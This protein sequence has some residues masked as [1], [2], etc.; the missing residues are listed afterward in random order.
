MDKLLRKYKWNYAEM[1]KRLDAK[2]NGQKSVSVR[3]RVHRDKLLEDVPEC[4]AIARRD[5]FCLSEI[6]FLTCLRHPESRC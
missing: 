4:A 2:Y 6:E 1:F 5:S 3:L